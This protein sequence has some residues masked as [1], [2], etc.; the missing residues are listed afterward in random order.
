MSTTFLTTAQCAD[1][2]GVCNNSI[3]NYIKKGKLQAIQENGI[4][5]I[6]QD[7]LLN[8][9]IQKEGKKMKKKSA[10]RLPSFVNFL[11]EWDKAQSGIF[12]LDSITKEFN[13]YIRDN[14]TE[15]QMSGIL[16]KM[17]SKKIITSKGRG[18]YSVCSQFFSNNNNS[19]ENSQEQVVEETKQ[20]IVSRYDI[21]KKKERKLLEEFVN[22]NYKE[23][24]DFIFTIDDVIKEYPDQDRSLM[25]KAV[26][27]MKATGHL[28]RGDKLGTYIKKA[29]KK[30][31]QPSSNFLDKIKEITESNISTQL[32]EELIR[33]ITK[34]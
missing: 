26:Q 34:D 22:K 5:K 27:N 17:K 13:R 2:L 14:I 33:K 11:Q 9:S 20:P 4:W 3:L 15:S 10:N 6:N 1:F 19:I 12:T 8:F 16:S 29:T 18:L 23:T 25:A 28:I 7:D 21:F 32:K 24:E 30:T 31:K